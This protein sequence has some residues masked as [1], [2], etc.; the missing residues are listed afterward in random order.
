MAS[1][2]E[3][4]A[5]LP[6]AAEIVVDPRDPRE[7]GALHEAK[8]GRPL[9]FCTWLM[10]GTRIGDWRTRR[11]L[12]QMA[13][14]DAVHRPDW[15]LTWQQHRPLDPDMAIV[16]AAASLA[17]AWQTR[18]TRSSKEVSPERTAAFGRALQHVEDQIVRA[19]QFCPKDPLPLA[20]A[21]EHGTGAGSSRD[22]VAAYAF[23][24]QTL[25]PRDVGASLAM[26]RHLSP[27]WYGSVAEAYDFALERSDPGTESATL[28]LHVLAD[29]IALDTT[30]PELGLRPEVERRTH[31][32][33]VLA[34][35]WLSTRPI[36]LDTVRAA[37]EAAFLLGMLGRHGDALVHHLGFGHLMTSEPWTLVDPADHGQKLML[38]LRAKAVDAHAG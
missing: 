4:V 17:D 2:D 24:A 18:G 37:N 14:A 13:A 7:H 3:I 31:E 9:R 23:E 8:Q 1:R 38:D 20:L 11:R 36:A 6:P 29:A 35:T 25:A 12:V 34:T 22:E 26:L 32:A 5:G 28:P 27:R 19:V 16:M 30:Q 15:V 33:M 21:I 10:E